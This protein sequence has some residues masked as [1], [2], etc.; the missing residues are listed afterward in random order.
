MWCIHKLAK[1]FGDI[2]HAPCTWQSFHKN[3]VHVNTWE[4][5]SFW[6]TVGNQLAQCKWHNPGVTKHKISDTLCM[7]KGFTFCPESNN[8]KQSHR[9]LD[10]KWSE[11]FPLHLLVENKFRKS[12][13]KLKDL[14][15]RTVDI[16]SQFMNCVHRSNKEI[17]GFAIN[18]VL[19]NV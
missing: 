12:G 11:I 1:W 10:R 5:N 3:A 2:S 7:G 9:I 19:W 16:T 4:Y 15:V 13:N 8:P 18:H 14:Q 17:N 6:W